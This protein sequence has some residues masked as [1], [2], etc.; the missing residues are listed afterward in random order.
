MMRRTPGSG[1]WWSGS[2]WTL[3]GKPALTRWGLEEQHARMGESPA[4][5]PK[6]VMAASEPAGFPRVYAVIKWTIVLALTFLAILAAAFW[7]L[8]LGG[9]A[10]SGFRAPDSSDGQAETLVI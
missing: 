2:S 8:I 3:P 5:A 4:Q 9:F 7:V 6:P 1:R 10:A